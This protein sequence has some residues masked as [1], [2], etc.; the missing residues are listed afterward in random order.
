MFTSHSQS[1]YL[2]C[3]FYVH[4]AFNTSVQ[5]PFV[6]QLFYKLFRLFFFYLLWLFFLKPKKPLKLEAQKIWI[7]LLVKQLF[8]VHNSFLTLQCIWINNRKQTKLKNLK[9]WLIK[10]LI[11][12]ID[13]LFRSWF[14]KKAFNI[15][16]ADYLFSEFLL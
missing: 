12:T 6:K 10:V 7:R 16:I 1:L 15:D 11:V 14:L 8:T 13:K 3:K 5:L 9:I 2:N 4:S